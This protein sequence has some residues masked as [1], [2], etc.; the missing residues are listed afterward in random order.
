MSWLANKKL[1]RSVIAFLATVITLAVLVALLPY[2]LKWGITSWL[3]DQGVEA[4][5]EA[6]K[7]KLYD[8]IVQIKAAKGSNSGGDGFEIGEAAIHVAWKPLWDKHLAIT[9]I[10][11]KH[12]KLD[13]VETRDGVLS[14]GGVALPSEGTKPQA[15]EAQRQP[16]E[17]SLA[18]CAG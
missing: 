15:Q 8:G 17:I 7:L 2:G 13:V 5:I 4:E 18:Y 9:K 6:I 16:E 1:K 10:S 11:F 12:F 14:V 3:E